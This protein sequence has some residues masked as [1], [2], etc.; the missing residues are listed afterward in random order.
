M[1]ITYELAP[2]PKW[3]ITDLFGKLADGAKIYTYQADDHSTKKTVYQDK[4]GSQPY[5][6]PIVCNGIG[7]NGPFY[8]ETDD[9][10]ATDAYY[11]RVTDKNNQFLWDVDDYTPATNGGSPVTNDVDVTNYFFNGQ[12]RYN[13]APETIEDS[14]VYDIA[15]GGWQYYHNGT[16]PTIAVTFPEFTPGSP[17]VPFFPKFSFNYNCTGAGSGATSN[18]IRFRFPDVRAFANSN[19]SVS[20]HGKSDTSSSVEVIFTQH[21]GTGGSPSAD[22]TTTPVAVSLDGT[23]TLKQDA[24]AVAIPSIAGK[25][26]GTNSDD[27]IEFAIRMP[28]NATAEVELSNMQL[29]RGDSITEFE[30]ETPRITEY[31]TRGELLPRMIKGSNAGET[32]WLVPE[33]KNDLTMAYLGGSAPVGSIVAHAAETAPSGWLECDGSSYTIA[34][35]STKQYERLHDVIGRRFGEGEL[36]YVIDSQVANVLTISATRTGAST[37]PSA[38]T[39]SFVLAAVPATDP[40]QVTITTTDM[41]AYTGGEHFDVY[42]LTQ[43]TRVY[44]TVDGAGAAPAV[45]TQILLKVDMLSTDT[46]TQVAQK[47]DVAMRNIQFKIPDLRGQ[48]IRGWDNGAGVDPDSGARTKSN[49]SGGAPFTGDHVGTKQAGENKAHTHAP[50]SPAGSFL[51]SG[52]GYSA[53]NTSSFNASAATTASSG[54]AETRPINIYMMYIIK[55]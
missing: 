37:A 1:A 9:A 16:N 27:Y 45:T 31:K 10:K 18:D 22:V 41:S 44:L 36:A 43:A 33:A 14:T 55:Y 53:G 34:E 19:V 17:D 51:G 49:E 7:E 39:T 38:G 29:E 52:T 54:G 24:K 12:F 2:I 8:W 6:N 25:G 23:W 3:Q 40:Q 26:I 48:F 5:S 13:V 35:G 28:L 4:G 21:F 15:D 11:I 46:S 47:L 20:F 42:N 50:L 32:D 30:Y